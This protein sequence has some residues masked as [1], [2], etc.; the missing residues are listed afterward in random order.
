MIDSTSCESVRRGVDQASDQQLRHHLNLITLM[1][2]A[3]D[4]SATLA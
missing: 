4:G 1:D 3:H 2:R